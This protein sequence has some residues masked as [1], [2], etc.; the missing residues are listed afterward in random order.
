MRLIQFAAF[1][2]IAFLG[3]KYPQNG[4]NKSKPNGQYLTISN[5]LSSV[6]LIAW[7]C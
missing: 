5:H 3:M 2:A 4:E 6:N 1:I 7:L